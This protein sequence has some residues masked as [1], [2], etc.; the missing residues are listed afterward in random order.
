MMFGNS[1]DVM[2]APLH[3]Y[4]QTLLSAVPENLKKGEDFK[5]IGE[6]SSPMN[7]PL[8]CV[9]SPRCKKATSECHGLSNLPELLQSKL[10]QNKHELRC[11]FN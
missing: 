7:P 6:P 11:I 9:Y 4:T 8:G 2:T 3:P 5:L 1:D 10:V